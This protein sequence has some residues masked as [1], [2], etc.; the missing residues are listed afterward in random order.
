MDRVIFM[1]W[2]WTYPWSHFF[3]KMV[4]IRLLWLIC[5]FCSDAEKYCQDIRLC[6]SHIRG[7]LSVIPVHTGLESQ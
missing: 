2:T 7:Y 4:N 3:K 1:T 5:I 6:Q